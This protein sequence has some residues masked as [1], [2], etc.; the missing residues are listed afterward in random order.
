MNSFGYF[1]PANSTQVAIRSMRWPGCVAEFAAGLIPRRPM[2]DQRRGD[3]AFVVEMLVAAERRVLQRR[4]RLAAEDL[5]TGAPGGSPS[6]L[7]SGPLSAL[8]PLSERKKISVLS[9]SP[10]CLQRSTSRPT[11]VSMWATHG[12]VDRHDVI[13]A[14]LLFRRQAVPRLYLWRARRQRPGRVHDAQFDL[15]GVPLL[16]E[17]V[18]ADLVLAAE[19]GDLVRGRHAAGN[20]AR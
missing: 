11:A 20:A 5:R 18:P 17:L 13:E 2:G 8:P 10:R 19:S 3:A 12:G 1:A 9:S 6:R 15:L 4:P 16:A 14:V 7:P